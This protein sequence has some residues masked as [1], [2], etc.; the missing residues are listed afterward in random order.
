M[1]G[2]GVA[3]YGRSAFAAYERHTGANAIGIDDYVIEAFPF[4]IQEISTDNGHEYQA[5]LQSQS[6]IKPEAD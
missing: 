1:S 5:R 2:S 3:V 6:R 4:R